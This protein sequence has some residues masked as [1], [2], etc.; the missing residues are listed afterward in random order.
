MV[1]KIIKEGDLALLVP[2][3]LKEQW[4][5]KACGCIFECTEKTDVKWEGGDQRDPYSVYITA[6]PTCNKHVIKNAEGRK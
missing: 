1:K 6:C 4:L 3:Y 2:W 5:C